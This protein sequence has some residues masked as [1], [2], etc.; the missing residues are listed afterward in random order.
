VLR[1]LPP[2][3]LPLA[4]L[5][6]LGLQCPFEPA[7][8]V[9]V[10]IDPTQRF[11]TVDGIGGSAADESNLRAMPEPDRTQVMDLVF[12]DLEPSVVRIKPRPAMEPANDDGDP[13]TTDADGF[14]RPDTHLWQ[15]AQILARGTPRL[16][17]ALWTPPAWMKTTGQ[18]CCGGTL[19]P[20][21][22]HELAEFFSV[23]L[24][25]LE[26]EGIEL[27]ALSIQNEPEAAS[28]WD[29]NTY[30]PA[31]YADTAETIAQRLLADGHAVPLSA[32]DTA[33]AAFTPLYTSELMQRPTVSTRLAAVA[34][35]HYQYSYYQ[36]AEIGG[37]AQN[38]VALSPPGLPVWMTEYSNTS[39]IGYGSWDE[40]IAQA[41]LVH[42]TFEAGVA[43]YVMWNLYRPGGPGEALVVIP[44]Q[45]GIPG[46]TVTPKY[47]TFRHY[48]KWVK[49]GARRIAAATPHPDLRVSA[50]HDETAG[51]VTAVFV[52]TGSE[53][54]WALVAGATGLG[55]PSQ[56]VQSTE[57]GPGLELPVDSPARFGPRA[58]R[59]PPRSVTTVVWPYSP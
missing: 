36:I 48:T 33:L 9:V 12:G 31:S 10:T 17:G 8:A 53:A 20:G 23:Y 27:D 52:H 59:L 16:I 18:E 24:D 54:V 49:P 1:I 42:A 50:F 41:E 35:H 28:P 7:P 26:A 13:A 40:A 19:L 47:W 44:T 5:A 46:Y 21:M 56:V 3:W 34:F 37:A 55:E 29:A 11:Q 25:Y 14:V 43:M 15:A 58:T 45:G 2:I 30:S 39:N 22:D 6:L 38:V 32:P 4:A 51:T 57:S